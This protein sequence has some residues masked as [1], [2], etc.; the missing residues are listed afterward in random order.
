MLPQIT[1]NTMNTFVQQLVQV[2]IIESELGVT[3]PLWREYTEFPLNISKVR[4]TLLPCTQ[5]GYRN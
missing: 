1:D 3:E 2:N 4:L 5:N